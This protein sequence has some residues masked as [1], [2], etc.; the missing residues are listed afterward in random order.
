MKERMIEKINDLTEQKETL[1]QE[2]MKIIEVKD[3]YNV[4]N[5]NID[6]ALRKTFKQRHNKRLIKKI[7][8]EIKKITNEIETLNKS[9]KV[10]EDDIYA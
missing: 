6:P 5:A 7:T 10:M 3:G 2:L 8:I 1:T 9:L 4:S